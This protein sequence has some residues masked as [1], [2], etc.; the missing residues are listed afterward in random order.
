MATRVTIRVT[1]ASG[2][3]VTEVGNV[4]YRITRPNGPGCPPECLQ[5]TVVV[6][7]PL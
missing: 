6:E 5:A 7:L 2:S 3:R 1:T 4:E